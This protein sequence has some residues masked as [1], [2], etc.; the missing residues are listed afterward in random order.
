MH[1]R[2]RRLK[3]IPVTC[4]AVELSPGTA[5]GMPVGRDIAQPEPAAIA[6]GGSGT[7]MARGVHLAA[8]SACGDD[9]GGRGTGGLRA[10]RGGVVTPVTIG[11][12]G[13]ARERGGGF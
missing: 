7:E 2:A 8:A 13:E 1:R 4:A 10:R 6:T 3:K 9:G 12:L 5:V 11:V